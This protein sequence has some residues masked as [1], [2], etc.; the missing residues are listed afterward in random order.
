MRPGM[1][2]VLMPFADE[3]RDAPGG[4]SEDGAEHSAE[5]QQDAAARLVR[6]LKLPDAQCEFSSPLLQKHYAV[7][8]AV[9]LGEQDLEWDGDDLFPSPA[10]IVE[11]IQAFADSLPVAQAT[12]PKRKAET[13]AGGDSKRAASTAE[14][15]SDWEMMISDGRIEK[16][17][18]ASLKSICA[19]L[20]L[21]VSGTKPVLISRLTEKAQG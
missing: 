3:I 11:S 13:A 20:G 5:Q 7:L 9:A 12:A 16:E 10:L 17:T 14:L 21:K 2:V 15:P 6:E 19:H 8:Q 1:H 4:V 18:V